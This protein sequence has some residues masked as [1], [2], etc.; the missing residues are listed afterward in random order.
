MTENRK[1]DLVIIGGAGHVG[2]PL[3]I[4]FANAGIKTLIYDINKEGLE[5]IKQGHVPFTEIGAEPVLKKCLE[6]KSISVSDKLEDIR[7]IPNIIITIGTPIDDFLNP[8]FKH[9]N[10]CIEDLLPFLDDDQLLILRST[11]TPGVTEWLNDKIKKSNK[12]TKVAFCPER[13]VQGKAVEELSKLPQLISGTSVEAIEQAKSLFAHI[14]TDLVELE[15]MEAEFAKLFCNAYRYIQFA[16]TNQFLM[17]AQQAGLDYTKILNAMKKNYKRLDDLP[18][19]GFAAGPCLL[20]DTMQLAAF[21]KNQFPLGMNAMMVNEGLPLF[22]IE[23]LRKV[24]HLK[25][26]KV[27]LLGMAFKA[28]IDDNRSSLSYK[29]KNQMVLHCDQIICT[30]PHVEN[31]KDL[32]PLEEALS[33]GDLFILCVPHDAYKGLSFEQKPVVDIWGFYEK[34]WLSTEI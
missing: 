20:K 15:P 22:I 28:N 32:V 24:Y 30:D 18:S 21:N 8:V 13:I 5:Q 23:Q 14:S 17:I 7:S 9:L 10:Q 16:A 26:M 11:I 33:V 1:F 3:G 34:G 31:D 12:K 2:L 25:S 6:E 19:A 29:F 27:V 4:V